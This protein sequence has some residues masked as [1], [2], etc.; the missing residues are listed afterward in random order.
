MKYSAY[1]IHCSLVYI[2]IFCVGMWLTFG[3]FDLAPLVLKSCGSKP[4]TSSNINNNFM[5]HFCDFS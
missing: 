3:C 4:H 5:V 1:N 2:Y